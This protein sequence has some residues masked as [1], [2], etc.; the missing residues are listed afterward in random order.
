MVYSDLAPPMVMS[1]DSAY[2]GIAC[3]PAASTASVPIS[4]WY[5]YPAFTPYG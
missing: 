2:Q 4:C 5:R 3:V 1:K